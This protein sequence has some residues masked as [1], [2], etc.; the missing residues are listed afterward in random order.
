V[1]AAADPDDWRRRMRAAWVARD[2]RAVEGL[3]RE[4]ETAAQPPQALADVGGLLQD[5]GSAEGAVRLLR[6]AQAASPGD[7][8][9][10]YNLGLALAASQPPQPGEAI[11]FLTVAV[12]LRPESAGARLGLAKTFLDKGRLDEA[13]AACRQA[14]GL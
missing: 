6:R 10:N 11:R 8:W 9:I 14:I 4:P 3:A 7:F 5:N 2:L 1:L 13:I 12:A